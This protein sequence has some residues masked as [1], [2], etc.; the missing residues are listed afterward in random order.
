MFT[1]NLLTAYL[2]LPFS[3]PARIE[4]DGA[5]FDIYPSRILIY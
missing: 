4:A 3:M 5:A 1:T 2:K